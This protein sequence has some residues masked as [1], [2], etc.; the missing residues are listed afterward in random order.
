[1]FGRLLTCP[2]SITDKFSP[3]GNAAPS[4]SR[5]YST[6]SRK[7]SSAGGS[8][9]SGKSGG[10]S[11]QTATSDANGTSR[12]RGADPALMQGWFG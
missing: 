8:G 7:T 5:T 6:T 12:D 10:K 9:H 4:S 3:I 1:M 2:C 11:I